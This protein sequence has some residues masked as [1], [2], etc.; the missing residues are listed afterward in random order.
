MWKHVS[1]PQLYYTSYLLMFIK[2]CQHWAAQSNK[3][4]LS[5][6]VS[7]G[8]ESR[9][10]LAGHLSHWES[11][12]RLQ[13]RCLLGLKSSEGL[14]GLKDTVL[15][16]SLITLGRRPEFL[17]HCWPEAS[18]PLHMSTY[19][20]CSWH[21]SRLPPQGSHLRE[22][23]HLRQMHSVLHNSLRSDIPL[24]L[25]Y[26]TVTQASTTRER[27][28]QSVSTK[29]Q[30]LLSTILGTGCQ[31]HKCFKKLFLPVSETRNMETGVERT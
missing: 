17:I 7:E 5:H 11:L 24:P 25:P 3:L 6:T 12:M 19:Q 22:Q 23:K 18:I 1:S 21:G 29:R 10:S 9:S 15:R 4:L 16:C 20:G 31:N 26:S 14:S 28:H 2:L 27:I 30:G 13:S 8:L